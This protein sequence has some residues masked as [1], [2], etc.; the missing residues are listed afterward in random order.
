MS[1]EVVNDPT[2]TND[3]I[4]S[5]LNNNFNR[6]YLEFMDFNE[7]RFVSLNLLFQSEMPQLYQLKPEVEKCIKDLCLDFM[8][9]SYVRSTDAFKINPFDIEKQLPLDKVYLGILAISRLHSIR[10]KCEKD[11]PSILIF[12]LPLVYPSFAYSLKTPSLS[13]LFKEMPFLKEIADLQEVDKEWRDESLCFNP[14]LN[15]SLTAEEY[16]KVVF[17][18]KKQQVNLLFPI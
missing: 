18:E 16:L 4:L 13:G 14:K 17:Q 1:D 8:D 12:Y 9:V 5:N 6:A 3:A 7:G 2:H 15:E 10:E 11:H